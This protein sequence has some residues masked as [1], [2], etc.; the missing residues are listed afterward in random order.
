MK[1]GIIANPVSGKCSCDNKH[2][3]LNE[4]ARI[5]KDTTVAGLDTK[6]PDEFAR[7]ARELSKTVNILLVAGGDGTFSLVMNNVSKEVP[8]GYLPFGSGDV[9]RHTFNLPRCPKENALLIQRGK[10]HLI[11]AISCD[12]KTKALFASIGIE[13]SILLERDKCLENNL[14][15]F[16]AY[17]LATFKI[18][19]D[20]Y[21]KADLRVSMDSREVATSNSLTAVITKLPYYGYG[22]KVVPQ[23]QCDDGYLHLL[24]LKAGPIGT[25]YALATSLAGGNRIGEYYKAREIN[26]TSSTEQLLQ[27][28]GDPEKE[29]RS[30]FSFK[31]LP[32]ELKLIF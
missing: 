8:L 15:G 3:I 32:K 2:K 27:R 7:C 22:F 21:I 5:L 9:L 31:V 25:L 11:D 12:G 10:E 20:G 30:H 13:G 19:F 26:I 17:G 23:A 4:V 28:N 16:T 6:S 24:I 14:L 29:K 1:Y 18:L